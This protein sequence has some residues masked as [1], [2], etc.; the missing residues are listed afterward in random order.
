MSRVVN[1]AEVSGHGAVLPT[2]MLDEEAMS[3]LEGA[4][5]SVMTLV[6]CRLLAAVM[7]PG[8]RTHSKIEVDRGRGFHRF[9][10]SGQG[11]IVDSRRRRL[12]GRPEGGLDKSEDDP[13][14]DRMAI[15]GDIAE[16]SELDI[17]DVSVKE[18]KTTP[19]KPFTDATLLSAMEHAG[20]MVA[21]DELDAAIDDDSSHSGGLELP[22]R[23]RGHHQH[24]IARLR[25]A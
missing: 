15:P 8:V 4:E 14:E 9:R 6:C 23:A 18:G 10:L 2:T 22:P 17:V 21:D 20:R 12:Q 25:R 24:I 13:S 1:D 16:G 19:P 3:R 5:R 11:R 7:E